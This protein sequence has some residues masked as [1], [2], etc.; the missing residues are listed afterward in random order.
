M[1]ISYLMSWE[2]SARR[3]WK[4]ADGKR[5]VVSVRQ[6]RKHF[7]E[8]SIGGTKEGSAQW[9]NRWWRETNQ[10]SPATR[11]STHPLVEFGGILIDDPVLADA[12]LVSAYADRNLPLPDYLTD[13]II[14]KT[15]RKELERGVHALLNSV[16]APVD[17]SVG[18]QVDRFLEMLFARH[19]AG[20][21]GVGEFSNARAGLVHFRDWMGCD[22]AVDAINA[23]RWQS[24]YLYLIG[25]DGPKSVESR[26]KHFRYA[27]NFLTWLDDLGIQS[28][29]PNL[30]RRQYRFK[31]GV[32]AVPSISTEVIQNTLRAARG[33]LKLHLLLM[34]NCGFTQQ[35]VSDLQPSEVDWAQGRIRRKRSKTSDHDK[36][37]FVDY[38]L[39]LETFT[40]LG[41]YR[42]NN[43]D[44]VLMTESG[45][46]WLRD[47]VDVGGTRSRTDAIRSCYRHLC[48]EGKQPLKMLR[49]ASSTLLDG[50]SEH[51]KCSASDGNGRTPRPSYIILGRS[52][53]HAKAPQELLAR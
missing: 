17:R 26:R 34:L 6:L 7:G 16:K 3:W 10:Q 4:M 47:S 18:H 28:V 35:D 8:P 29:P 39:W 27:R 43:P 12:I 52:S 11:A 51:G 21:I 25:A 32:K 30:N 14:G 37:P 48:V 23:E 31:G 1:P 49:K 40:L 2:A 5:Y 45:K 15:R 13:A 9:A 33:Q 46:T 24:Y 19:N 53:S 20:E 50:S 44:H 38:L 22:H 41:R 36:V 42:S